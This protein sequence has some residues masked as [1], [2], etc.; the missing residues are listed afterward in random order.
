MDFGKELTISS[1]DSC[2]Y[3]EIESAGERAREGRG[4]ERVWLGMYG[5]HGLVGWFL[6]TFLSSG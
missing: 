4:R 2:R 1:G 5:V 6:L 3:I